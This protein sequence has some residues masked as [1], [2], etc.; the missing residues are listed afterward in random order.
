MS[1]TRRNNDKYG[2]KMLHIAKP[3]KRQ[4]QKSLLNDF[5][6]MYIESNRSPQISL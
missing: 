2:D 6:L 4:K 5:E 1:H 3:Y